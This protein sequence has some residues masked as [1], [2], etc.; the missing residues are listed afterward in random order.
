VLLPL[1][2]SWYFFA[3]YANAANGGQG[4]EAAAPRQQAEDLLDRYLLAKTRQLVRDVTEQMDAYDI[5]G[6]CETVR[7]YA[8]MLT[9]WYIRRSRQ[10]FWDERAEAFDTLYTALETVCRVAAPLLP[11]VTEEIWRGLTGGRSVHLQDWPE[12]SE[13]ASADADADLVARMDRIRQVCSVA[14]GVRKANGLRVRLPLRSLTVV[15]A[16]AAGLAELAPIVAD[17][18]NVHEVRLMD[19]ADAGAADF[20]VTERLT[21]NARAA[22]PRLGKD[23]Q[24]AIHAAK[25]GLWSVAEDGT[26]SAGDVVLVEGEYTVETVVSGALGQE[27]RNAVA[28]LP[29][30]GFVVLDT[31]VTAELAAVGL[32]RDV[33]RV[34]QQARRDAGLQVSDRIRLTVVGDDEVWRAVL[35]NQDLIVGETLADSF[36]AAG[37]LD[38]LPAGEGVTLATVGDGR[39]VRV[40]VERLVR[41]TG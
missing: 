17:E 2:S 11:L 20:G 36:G 22:G 5:A 26:V 32:A 6:A 8:D 4:Y 12:V 13:Q 41:Y 35:A 27:S 21:V 25:A 3:L 40:K 9:N 19:V 10:R 18:V 31:E 33:V 15:T 1:W 28:V 7:S 16:D 14:L 29:G 39:T 34:V 24:K 23:V 38:A 37:D 30:E